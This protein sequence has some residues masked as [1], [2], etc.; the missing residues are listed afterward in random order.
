MWAR[1]IWPAVVVAFLF[2]VGTDFAFGDATVNV[3]TFVAVFV[4][5]VL[6]RYATLAGR[7]R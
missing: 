4:V 3:I 6:I 2:D 7:P 5:V 1:V